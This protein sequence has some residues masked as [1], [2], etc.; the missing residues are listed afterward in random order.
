MNYDRLDYQVSWNPPLSTKSSITN[1]PSGVSHPG[2]VT[3]PSPSATFTRYRVLWAPRK[4]EPVDASMY[5]DEAG[6]SPIPDLQNSDVRVLDKVRQFF[7]TIP[8][9]L[10]HML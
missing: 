4:D 8:A 7:A 1:F 3:I 6:F 10:L 2:V 5:N 9:H